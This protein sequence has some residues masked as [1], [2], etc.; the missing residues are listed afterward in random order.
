MSSLFKSKK[1]R[2]PTAMTQAPAEEP[3]APTEAEVAEE[4]R[5]VQRAGRTSSRRGTSSLETMLRSRGG[6]S[7]TASSSGKLG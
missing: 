4:S 5:K 3:K 2:A 7:S 1:P 6:S